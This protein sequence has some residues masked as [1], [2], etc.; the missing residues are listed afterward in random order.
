MQETK[1]IMMI[2][3]PGS[4]KSTLAERFGKDLKCNVFSSDAYRK[5]LFGDE[6]CQQNPELVFNTLYAEMI[7]DLKNNKDCIFD[8]TNMSMKDRSRC[9]ERIKNI[10]NLFKVAYVVNT[11]IETCIER[12]SQRERT[13]GKEVI[14]RMILK[15]E[16][17]QKFEG[18]DQIKIH[19]VPYTSDEFTNHSK[20]MKLTIKMNGFNQ[21]NP[22]HKYDLLGHTQKLCEQFY[23]NPTLFT[24]SMYHDVGKLYTQT[25]DEKGIS[26]YYGHANYSAYWLICNMDVL[27]EFERESFGD[28]IFYINYHMRIRDILNSKNPEKYRKLFGD[29]RYDNLVKF[30]E[31]DNIATGLEN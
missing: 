6:A 26:H 16:F 23:D 28:V 3:A 10:P 22:H 2:G 8:A 31:A 24:A 18:F 17:P 13:V 21:N 27:T 30:M 11:P 7:D 15:F 9:L 19:Q 20:K 5:K 14:N 4:G 12:D 1:F 25:T 29:E